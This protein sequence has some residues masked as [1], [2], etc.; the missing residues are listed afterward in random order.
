MSRRGS[1]AGGGA[2]SADNSSR[3][4]YTIVPQH[5][6][7]HVMRDGDDTDG[8]RDVS[9]SDS[10]SALNASIRQLPTTVSRHIPYEFIS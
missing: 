10:D 4:V 6:M 2:R 3:K 5:A 1:G 8:G 9:L 7:S